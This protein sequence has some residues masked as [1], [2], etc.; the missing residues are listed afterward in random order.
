MKVTADD[1]AQLL[2]SPAPRQVPPHVL[3]AARRNGAPWSTAVFGL[4]FGS[5]G[6]IFVVVFFPWR[7]A[8]ELR[9]SASGVVASGE[10]VSVR[11]TNMSVNKRKVSEY[12]FTYAPPGGG[13]AQAACY[14]SRGRWQV[15]E[16]VTVHCVPAQPGLATIDGGRLNQAG[17]GGLITGI[18]PLVGYSMAGWFL[19]Q[20]KRTAQILRTGQLAE[21]DV[22]SVRATGT[23]VNDRSVFAIELASPALGAQPVTIKRLNEADIE[24]AEKH[25][26]DKQPVFV[27]YDP[28]RPKALVLPEGLIDPPTP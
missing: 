1:I 24:L 17:V 18:F 26:A 11:D 16:Q 5:F 22:L 19:F 10:V 8:D 14:A 6:M 9:L 27:L 28:R 4:I 7:L 23:R 25:V 2:A 12:R 3:K 13:Q 20:R 15:G 21:V